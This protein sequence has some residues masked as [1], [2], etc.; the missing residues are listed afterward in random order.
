VEFTWPAK[1]V[2]VENACLCNPLLDTGQILVLCGVIV[3]G[4]FPPN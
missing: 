1:V 2:A 4:A 3:V